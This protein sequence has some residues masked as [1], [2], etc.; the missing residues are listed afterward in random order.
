MISLLIASA[1]LFLACAT[2]GATA[3]L[4]LSPRAEVSPG[5]PT[6][7]Y[8]VLA[9]EAECSTPAKEIWAGIYTHGRD[10]SPAEAKYFDE[11]G[12]R[13][14]DF[15]VYAYTS[16]FN[17]VAAAKVKISFTEGDY[18]VEFALSNMLTGKATLQAH[19]TERAGDGFKTFE[20]SVLPMGKSF[21]VRDSMS[22]LF[23]TVC[24]MGKDGKYC[25]D[26][27]IDGV[28][29]AYYDSGF[30]G[31][32]IPLQ[33]KVSVI[34]CAERVIYNLVGVFGDGSGAGGAGS[35]AGDSPGAVYKE[36]VVGFSSFM[37]LGVVT[38]IEEE[39]PKYSPFLIYASNF[40]N[41][42]EAKIRISLSDGNYGFDFALDEKYAEA[43]RLH[44]VEIEPV[45]EGYRAYDLTVSPKGRSFTLDRGYS[46]GLISIICT[47]K[48]EG[49]YTLD[50]QIE[51]LEVTY[52]D[53]FYGDGVGGGVGGGAGDGVGGGVGGGAGGEMPLPAIA[54]I[55]RPDA[56]DGY[57][58]P[59][60][61][62]L[63]GDGEVTLDDIEY[64][65]Q[66]LGAEMGVSDPE[67]WAKAMRCDFVPDGKI[68]YADL[69]MIIF[70]Y[71]NSPT[72]FKVG[73][74]Y[75]K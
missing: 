71:E 58:L 46:F 7:A 54:K 20:V 50:A 33:A 23:D 55:T 13:Y 73:S 35:G 51:A 53:D 67:V 41:V 8:A 69:L 59:T 25:V 1:L 63:D 12:L 18:G 17:D 15:T 49:V 72:I 16:N 31:G 3:C 4:A 22:G 5:G 28:E 34:N 29:I 40:V 30:A 60:I 9:A 38:F 42:A 19:E 26:A 64:V 2:T 62:D 66:C 37:R 48:T 65:R 27:L 61:F 11:S 44:A 43:A 39:G 10:G 68:D 57:C 45:S 32:A 75:A 24:V 52:Y 70:K 14:I 6:A 47:V 36:A 74:S 21:S 56:D